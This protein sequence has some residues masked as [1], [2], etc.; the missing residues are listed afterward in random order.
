MKQVFGFLTLVLL[1]S[2]CGVFSNDFSGNGIQKRK[3]TKGFYINKRSGL[4]ASK[5]EVAKSELEGESSESLVIPA[6][7]MNPEIQTVNVPVQVQKD[8][9]I[10]VVSTNSEVK[11]AGSVSKSE[12]RP[13]LLGAVS[14]KLQNT[15]KKQ[16]QN[17][18]ISM[19]R[20]NHTSDQSAGGSGGGA[21]LIL[22]VILAF[23]LPPLAVALFD[24]ISGRFWIDL[25]LFVIGIGVGWLIF[26]GHLAWICGVAAVI[27]A[28]LILF[29]V[30]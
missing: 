1:L 30:I 16:T 4:K 15:F 7:T 11:Q 5:G 25:L 22:L 6:E 3:Y 23:I 10:E 2:S 20:Q 13:A 17:T 24:G 19:I 26:G 27:Y 29:S 12:S 28:L 9:Q 18:N 14:Q 8:A 21:M